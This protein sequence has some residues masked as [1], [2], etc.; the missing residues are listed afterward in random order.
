MIVGKILFLSQN[1]GQSSRYKI[2]TTFPEGT[3]GHIQKIL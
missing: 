1:E 2:K 3:E